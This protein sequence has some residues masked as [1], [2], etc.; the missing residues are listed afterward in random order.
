MAG[1]GAQTT[2]TES[3]HSQI[4]RRGPPRDAAHLLRTGQPPLLPA[5]QI[6]QEPEEKIKYGRNLEEEG[7]KKT[8]NQDIESPPSEKHQDTRQARRTAR[9]TY[10]WDRGIRIR[11]IV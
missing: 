8:G 7:K 5:K 9:C 11:H 2:D 1:A 4:H 6:N 10:G 3:R